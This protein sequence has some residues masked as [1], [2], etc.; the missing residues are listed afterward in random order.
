MSRKRRTRLRL[1]DLGRL[2]RVDDRRESRGN[3]PPSPFCL[4]FLEAPRGL[5]R[6]SARRPTRE[7]QWRAAHAVSTMPAYES[8]RCGAGLRSVARHQA[9]R[10]NWRS[11]GDRLTP[12]RA[13]RAPRH[14]RLVIVQGER[15]GSA[16]RALAISRGCRVKVASVVAAAAMRMRGAIPRN[17]PRPACGPFRPAAVRWR[18]ARA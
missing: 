16:A 7:L 10:G 9:R 4:L 11:H 13:S 8:S 6:V 2:R 5:R 12:E 15:N 1:H 18:V 17:R 14:V 3:V